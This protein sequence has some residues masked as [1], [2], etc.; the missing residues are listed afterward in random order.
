MKQ[1]I[2][3]SA[4]FFSFLVYGQESGKKT[5]LLANNEVSLYLIGKDYITPSGNL[6]L[7]Q[8]HADV[9]YKLSLTGGSMSKSGSYWKIQPA[10]GV[11]KIYLECS[12]YD[13][14]GKL[15]KLKW[16][17]LVKYGTR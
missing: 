1:A 11:R 13:R 8:E 14:R 7:V 17:F 6:I 9:E 5:L 15:A 16:E 2:L 10:M 3:F 12:Y 4:I